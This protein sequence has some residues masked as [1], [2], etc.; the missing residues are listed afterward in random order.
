MMA[1]PLLEVTDLNV[2]FELTGMN[3]AR[4]V[5]DKQTA[6]SGLNVWFDDPDNVAHVVRDVSFTLA[7][8]ERIG[9]VGES[10]CGK[11]TALLALMGLLPP[12]ATLSGRVILDGDDLLVAGEDSVAPHRWKDVAMVFQGAM[13]AFNPVR[14]IGP[15]L[16]EPMELHHTSRGVAARQ[17]AC[18][19]L[20]LVGIPPQRFDAFPHELSGG[21][22]QR[23]A[24]AMALACEPKLLLADEPTT[25]L[26]VIVQ[27]QVLDLLAHLSDQLGL[28]VVLVTHD[29]PLVSGLCHRT[30]VMYAG[31]VAELGASKTIVDDPEH[32]YTRMLFAATPEID[33]EGA[34]ASIP[35]TPPRLDRE[36]TGCAFAP[37]CDVSID[38]CLDGVPALV[39]SEAGHEVRCI[40]A[41]VRP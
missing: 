26:D 14:R 40:R 24:I 5:A 3:P 15:Q 25:A 33:G 2:W 23:A 37:R 12:N 6:M 29:L 19:L 28:A 20:D 38:A 22:R 39:A 7:R 35:G 1:E 27:A 13:N 11:T 41:G 17:R 30:A 10:G 21:Q 18:E 36:F 9:L 31:Q 34:I 32:P 8:G 4:R 16:V